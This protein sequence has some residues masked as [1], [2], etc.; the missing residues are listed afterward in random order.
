MFLY[1]TISLVN[2]TRYQIFEILTIKSL[3]V[4]YIQIETGEHPKVNSDFHDEVKNNMPTKYDSDTKKYFMNFFNEW[5]SHYVY[6]ALFGCIDGQL[7]KMTSKNYSQFTSSNLDI[8]YA[9]TFSV[10]SKDNSQKVQGDAFRNATES[11]KDI[12]RGA[13]IP[14]GKYSEWLNACSHNPDIIEFNLK[15]ISYGLQAQAFMDIHDIGEKREALGDATNDYC[16]LII[17]ATS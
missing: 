12:T 8:E 2:I 9:S 14:N 1:K 16:N 4:Q 13:K 11:Q 17:I 10:Y 3:T 5:G 6:E 15:Q 7:S